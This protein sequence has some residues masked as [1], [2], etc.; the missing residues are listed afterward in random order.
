MSK[1]CGVSLD[2]CHHLSICHRHH[3]KNQTNSPL[4]KGTIVPDLQSELKKLETLA[5]D[6]EGKTT[7]TEA[8][9]PRVNDHKITNN[10][11]R[12]T[13]NYIKDNPGLRRVQIATAME[14]RGF[15]KSSTLAL[16]SQFVRSGMA[17]IVDSGVFIAQSEYAPPKGKKIKKAKVTK[18]TAK[19]VET[20]I[21]ESVAQPEVQHD[22]LV[23]AM[24][25]RMSILQAREMYDELK[26]VFSS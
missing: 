17:R 21:I 19:K 15:K 2:G 26:K 25:S 22:T 5:F 20:H 1:Q 12:E 16:T 4:I 13:F 10:V 11:T 23:K 14:N 9:M 6:D 8:T 24:L 3:P 7:T 18:V